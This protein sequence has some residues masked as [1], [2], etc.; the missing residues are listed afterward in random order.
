[1]TWKTANGK[2][3]TDQTVNVKFQ[4]PEFTEKITVNQPFHVCPHDLDYDMIIGRETLVE[5]GIGIDF[6]EKQITWNDIRVDMKDPT[7]FDNKENLLSLSTQ[8]DPKKCQETLDRAMHILNAGREKESNL[9]NKVSTYTH[10][11]EL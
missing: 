1:M 5:L 2:F 10:L 4:L 9:S 3:S 6:L 11:K 8:V 7:L